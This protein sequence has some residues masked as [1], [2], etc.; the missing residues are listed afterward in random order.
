MVVVLV[1]LIIVGLALIVL[2][3]VAWYLSADAR[4]LSRLQSERYSLSEVVQAE[5][6]K[7]RVGDAPDNRDLQILRFLEHQRN[8][9]DKYAAEFRTQV[10]TRDVQWSASTSTPLFFPLLLK[11]QKLF[12][13]A[14]IDL[15]TSVLDD[16]TTFDRART[17]ESFAAAFE[18][19]S[20]FTTKDVALRRDLKGFFTRRTN[21]LP[22]GEYQ[23]MLRRFQSHVDSMLSELSGVSGGPFVPKVEAMV[24]RAYADAFFR[25]DT[26]PD[27]EECAILV[28]RIW[29]IKS[30]RNNIPY[31]QW[32]PFLWLKL[33][34]LQERLFVIVSKAQMLV[35][36]DTSQA[37]S[38]MARIYAAHGYPP[39]NLLNALIPLYEAI[40]R[41]VIY[42][43]SELAN[44]QAVQ[45]ELHHEIVQNADDELRYCKST[46]TLLHRVW[47][48]TLRLHPP[49]P[50]QTRRVTTRDHAWFP[51]DSKVLVVWSVFHLDP[52]IWGPDA[53]EF[54]PRRW[55]DITP[56]QERH[57][58]PFG[59]GVQRCVATNYASFGGRV[60]IK[61][62]VESA[63]IEHQ[64]VDAMTP[65]VG[66][67]RGYS[68]GPEPDALIL[69][70]IMRP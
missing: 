23:G 42:A 32:N 36:D 14:D 53:A 67:D 50:N 41:G 33:R 13:L 39:G 29:Q 10:T 38:D 24:L 2:G 55:H 47:Q 61:R 18:L 65:A 54:S 49:T 68:R 5:L 52:Q 8:S 37:T 16:A 43:V 19:N 70:L 48:E 64:G 31:H 30:L 12:V 17:L 3:A 28:K 46:K 22:S 56:Q 20:V 58:N 11:A 9:P 6:A 15:V 27:A 60:M 63:I 45:D 62:I 57:Y 59:K 1:S 51:Y 25:I 35:D 34:G 7:H 26:F 66:N 40:A 69:R 44:S 4:T 21:D